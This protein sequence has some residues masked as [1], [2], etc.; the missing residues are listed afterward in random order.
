MKK[1]RTVGEIDCQFMDYEKVNAHF[2]WKPKESFNDGILKTIEWYKEE[3]LK[4]NLEISISSHFKKELFKEGQISSGKSFAVILCGIS[5]TVFKLSVISSP[6]SP[7][8]L[9]KPEA[10]IPFL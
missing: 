4:R 6:C 7:S 9:D 5:F 2:G 1:N 10:S 8:P 3:S